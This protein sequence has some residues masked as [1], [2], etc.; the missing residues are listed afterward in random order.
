MLHVVLLPHHSRIVVLHLIIPIPVL[1]IVMLVFCCSLNKGNKYSSLLRLNHKKNKENEAVDTV[2]NYRTVDRLTD[3]V[4]DRFIDPRADP[5]LLVN[6]RV[7]P[8]AEGRLLTP[9]RIDPRLDSRLQQLDQEVEATIATKEDLRA[10]PEPRP[11]PDPEG[12]LPRIVP[13]LEAPLSREPRQRE[14]SKDR[15][16]DLKEKLEARN[17]GGGGGGGGR[18]EAETKERYVER[19]LEQLS[20][21]EPDR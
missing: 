2:I 5:R 13:R 1:H 3:R 8:R 10:E 7:D 9:P 14:P 21:D 20:R 19:Y 15:S 12:R 16:G 11:R 18:Q 17:G 6:P 4:S